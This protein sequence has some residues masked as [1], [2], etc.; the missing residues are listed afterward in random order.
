MRECDFALRMLGHE[1]S[2][3]Y[4]DKVMSSCNMETVKFVLQLLG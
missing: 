1:I 4:V 3:V 2:Q